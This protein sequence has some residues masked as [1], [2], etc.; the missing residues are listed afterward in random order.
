[1]NEAQILDLSEDKHKVIGSKKGGK[2]LQ[3]K[4]KL[5]RAAS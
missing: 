4:D 3:N 1:M 5:A 2:G